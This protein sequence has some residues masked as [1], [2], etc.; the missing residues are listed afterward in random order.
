MFTLRKFWTRN[1]VAKQQQRTVA[2]QWFKGSYRMKESQSGLEN[3]F[4]KQKIK[5]SAWNRNFISRAQV[6]AYAN[7][8]WDQANEML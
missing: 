4:S 7:N 3:N 8:I 6:D 2:V 5:S 1:L